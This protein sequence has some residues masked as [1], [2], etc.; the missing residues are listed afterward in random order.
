MGSIGKF[1]GLISALCLG[2]VQG[3]AAEFKAA[4]RREPAVQNLPLTDSEYVM[5][6][7]F[8]W[9]PELST[10]GPVSI[11]VNLSMQKLEVFRGGTLIARSSIS[12]GRPG[13]STPVGTYT[14]LEKQVMHHS[15][16]YH[17]APMPFMQRL[18]WHGV[19]MHAGVLPGSPAS[20]GC[21]R[22]P[23]EFAKKL[24]E[25]TSRGDEVVV[26][27]KASEFRL[28]SRVSQ[29]K[30]AAPKKAIIVNTP[31]PREGTQLASENGSNRVPKTMR[32]LEAEEFRIRNAPELTPEQRRAE[33]NRV[34][35]SQRALT[36][37]Q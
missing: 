36:D 31:L 1:A 8:E 21:I 22:L 16:L 33:L 30:Q 11:L 25:I 19:A 2:A 28:P 7:K 9:Q 20:H 26:D 14:I 6:G 37:P 15:N 18:T 13:H 35:S 23:S 32:E 27:G 24:Y 12:S 4:A 10:E 3:S 5:P 34:W 29:R 17:N